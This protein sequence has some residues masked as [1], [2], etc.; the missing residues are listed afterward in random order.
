VAEPRRLT[1]RRGWAFALVVGIIKP[2]LLVYTRPT[3]T[4]GDRI[5]SYGGAVLA[6]NHVSHLDPLTFAHFVYDQGRLPRYLAKAALFDVFFVGT[7][8]RSTGQIPVQRLSSEAS[9]AFSAA[10]AAVESG[11]IV[12]VYPE[13]TLTRQPQLWPM[14][15]KTGA[16]RIALSSGVPVIPVAQW[17]AQDVLYPYAK[18]PRLLPRKRVYA[19]AGEPVPLD[20][21]REAQVTPE[22]LR[23]ATDRI[24]EAITSLLEDIRGEQAPTE[25]FDP[26]KAGVRL[27]GNPRADEVRRWR[28]RT[29]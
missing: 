18:W 19:K 25:R 7:I 4:N 23:E 17:G 13:G 3:W 12:V 22:V 14:V 11:R 29:R 28:R 1:E 16:A 5:P 20:D 26:R 24:M 27:T 21:L 9:H 8:L 15:G 6:A 10:V 2:L